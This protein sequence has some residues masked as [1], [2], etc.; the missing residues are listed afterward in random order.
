MLSVGSNGLTEFHHVMKK[1][2][3]NKQGSRLGALR[4]GDIIE[5]TYTYEFMGQYDPNTGL[6]SSRVPPEERKH[7]VDHRTAHTVEEFDDLEV[8]VWVQDTGTNEV[9]QSEWS[10]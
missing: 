5:D 9:L 8:V 4:A 1:M 3:P 6:P 2:V 7:Y 10:Q